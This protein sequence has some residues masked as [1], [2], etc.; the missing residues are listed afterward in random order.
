MGRSNVPGGFKD[1]DELCFIGMLNDVCLAEPLKET[2]KETF[3][4]YIIYAANSLLK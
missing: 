2:S 1:V 4:I 3:R